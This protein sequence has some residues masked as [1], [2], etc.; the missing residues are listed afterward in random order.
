MMVWTD[1][2]RPCDIYHERSLWTRLRMLFM[3]IKPCFEQILRERGVLKASTK[4]RE[5]EI[6]GTTVSSLINADK[7]IYF[8]LNEHVLIAVWKIQRIWKKIHFQLKSTL[9]MHFPTFGIFNYFLVFRIFNL[10]FY[11]DVFNFFGIVQWFHVQ[12]NEFL[13]KSKGSIVT[14]FLFHRQLSL[15]RERDSFP[16][17]FGSFQQ[18]YELF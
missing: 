9:P 15:S 3:R 11:F 16:D 10:F 12:K 1:W 2:T 8:L 14:I 6:R 18:F 4:C 5:L 13:E 17:Y 7:W